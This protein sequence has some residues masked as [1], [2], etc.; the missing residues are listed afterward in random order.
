VVSEPQTMKFKDFFEL[1]FLPRWCMSYLSRELQK[2][3]DSL[4]QSGNFDRV[5]ISH[6]YMA[7]YLLKHKDDIPCVVDHHNVKSLFF[8]N[9]A[10]S[11]KSWKMKIAYRAEKVRW[12]H[13]EREVIPLF[14][15]HICCSEEEQVLVRGMTSGKVHL[16]PSGVDT[17]SFRKKVEPFIGANLLFTGSL[18][19][20]PNTQAVTHFCESCLLVIREAIP[21]V[22]LQVVGKNPTLQIER[23]LER[24]GNTWYSYNVRDIRPFYYQ[25]SVFVVPLLTGAGTRLKILE[26]M[27][28]GLPVVSTSKGCEGLGLQNGQG[29]LIEDNPEA[30]AA[31]IIHLLNDSDFRNSMSRTAFEI[32][33]ERFSWNGIFRRADPDL[34]A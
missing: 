27:A 32:C 24:T 34:F 1:R 31:G 14:D 21:Q 23:L 3:I 2:L 10:Q 8:H 19:Y 33:N 20:F 26:A 30:M 13:Y 28:V 29:I 22:R 7:W 15:E 9:A 11:T 18:D 12:L 4:L 16:L 25:S 17:E 6:S 5:H